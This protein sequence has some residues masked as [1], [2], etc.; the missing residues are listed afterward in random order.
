MSCSIAIQYALDST[1][2]TDL[3]DRAQIR[4]WVQATRA[5]LQSQEAALSDAVLTIRF[6]DAR[7]GRRLNHDHRGRDYATNVLTFNLHE[8]APAGLALPILADLI[9]CWPVVRREAREQRKQLAHHAAH[10]IVHGVL[11]AHGYDHERARDAKVMEA[12]ERLIL[13]RFRVSDPYALA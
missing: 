7:E 3:P 11:H 2:A 4:R 8:D 6:V 12:L 5:V 1:R 9:V 13:A 10:M